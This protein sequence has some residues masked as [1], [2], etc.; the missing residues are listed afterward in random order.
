MFTGI[1]EEIGLVES[2]V[3]QSG[4]M[5]FQIR[6]ERVLSDLAVDQSIAVNGVCLTVVAV[7]DS[8]FEADV[9][10]ETLA[11]STLAQLQ[12][13]DRVNLERA[14]RLQD[15]LGGHLVQGHVDGL[16]TIQRLRFSPGGGELT[17]SIPSELER[18]TIEKGSIA[19]DGVSL[20]IAK[21]S[22]AL[23]SIAVIPHTWNQTILQFKKSGD[24]VNIEVD[25]LAKYIE[26]LIW[27]PGET[28]ITMEW[29][30][31]QGF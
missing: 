31:Q 19:I 16:G 25:C 20:T 18:Y 24:Q 1:I 2:N 28:N 9:V 26:Q 6:A 13:H 27:R 23:I 22:G 3:M 14:L 5:R 7:G 21:K 10:A 17:I 15:R 8:Y 30:K 4:A 11:R 29:L 12:R